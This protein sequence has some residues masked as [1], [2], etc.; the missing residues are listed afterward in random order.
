MGDDVG[1]DS[2]ESDETAVPVA[3][4]KAYVGEPAASSRGYTNY[5]KADP[6]SI[7]RRN[8]VPDALVVQVPGHPVVYGFYKVKR[9][10]TSGV[11]LTADLASR[12]ELG[13][14][15]LNADLGA[16]H[17]VNVI[18]LVTGVADPVYAD[19]VEVAWLLGRKNDLV[20]VL[21]VDDGGVVLWA[22]IVSISD[23]EV[24]RVEAREQLRGADFN[25]PV[26]GL[27]I[28]RNLVV[29]HFQRTPLAKYEYLATA[30]KP[31][32]GVLV[33][34]YVFV[35]VLTVG[36]GVW[37]NREDIFHEKT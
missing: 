12:W 36:L 7:I 22:R 21:G 15:E 28:L 1:V 3:W 37:A 29:Q 34:L 23:V 30:A 17:Q 31:S 8:G 35:I 25:N 2:C 9:L 14:D 11:K 10:L 32:G 20:F 24:L 27:D 33:F 16:R 6:E 5:L 26:A 4:A 18:V 19:A 13:L